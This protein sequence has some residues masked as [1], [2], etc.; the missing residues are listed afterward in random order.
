MRG[1]VLL[2]GTVACASTGGG[3]RAALAERAA[4]D[5]VEIVI[6]ATT[7]VHGRL[8][9]WD[10]YTGRPDSARGLARAATIIDSLRR[11]HAGR[12]VLLDAGDLL[13]GNPL[14]YHAARLDTLGL[15]PVIA[16]M[17]TM[18][19]AAAAVGN[20]E[21]NYGLHILGRATSSAT[22][23][24][25]AANVWRVN[26]ERAF[27][28][29]TV[30]E[31][32]GVRVAI[33]GAT[34]PGVM[35]WDRDKVSGRI[36]VR[37]I[38]PEVRRAVNEVRRAGADVVVVAIH[39]GFDEP[40]SYDTVSSGVPSENVSARV[41]REVPGIDVLVYGHSHR[42]QPGLTIESTLLIQPR[43]WATSVAIATLRVVRGA[44]VV[45][46]R[47]A[48]VQ[49][50]GHVE[51]SAV[52]AAVRQAHEGT[53][54]YVAT[55]VGETR[56]YWRGDSARVMDTPLIDF[57]NEVQ[58]RRTNSD[59]SAASAFSA[60]G[61]LDSGTITLA[62]IAQVYPY[63]N[64]LRAVRISGAQLRAY[65]EYSARYY[66]SLGS[67]P[68]I[69][70]TIPG[71]NFDIISGADYT[72]DLSKPLGA[73]VTSLSARGRPVADSD[74]FT[75]ALNDY[76]QSGGAG[77]AMLRGAPVVYDAKED[78]RELLI[79]EVRRRGTLR[80]EDFFVRNWRIEPPA[81]VAQ[82]AVELAAAPRPAVPA[83]VRRDSHLTNGRW[84]RVIATND[85]HGALEPR[86]DSAGGVVR[87]GAPYLAAEIAQARRACAA[88][89]C[90]SL[91]LDGGD[92]FQG[93][94]AS[95]LAYGRPVMTIFN[96][97]G[98]S[99][100]ALG[101]H[102][103]DWGID[104]LRALMRDA[105]YP[106]LGANVR[107][108]Q[109]GDIPWIPDDT[110]VTAGSLK[111]GVI[112]A[113]LVETPTV[114]KASVVKDLRFV[115][116][117]PLIDALSRALRARGADV[118]IVVAH[119]GAFCG[120]EVTTCRGAIVDLAARL[121]ERVD[122][123]VSGHTHSPV[124]GIVRGIPIVQARSRGTALGMIDIPLGDSAAAPVIELRDVRADWV[125]PDST[126]AAIVRAAAERVAERM[127]VPVAEIGENLSLGLRS[128]LGGLIADAQRH[129]GEGDVALM[130]N[131]GVRAPIR[132]GTATVGSL[133]EVHPF[134]NRLVR[135]Q[136]TGREL[137]RE[138]E[139]QVAQPTFNLHVSGA[140]I[141]FD[142][143]RPAGSRVMSL[144]LSD[145]T[146][147]RDRGRYRVVLSD[148]LAD[149]GD[150]VQLAQSA[151]RRED[152][153]ITDLDVL[154]A[155]FKTLP[156]PV[157]A[158]RDVRIRFANP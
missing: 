147:I 95:N 23:P 91:W 54:R 144:T 52:V 10:Y 107:D 45:A 66:R 5:T 116:P 77:F 21:F 68:L 137:R 129:V 25:L 60:T 85:F 84:L 123:I 62:Q 15:H 50:A 92:M 131:G 128:P 105:R 80:H 113:A 12:V 2:L 110:L 155:Y 141:V 35:I 20:H 122:A 106:I 48:V 112:G 130:N 120:R 140:R 103:F 57:I 8:R 7:D 139:R 18:R 99:A 111:V 78:I 150:G 61:G 153:G 109:G 87:G 65:L 146:P 38:V 81:A 118:V 125:N 151:L 56:V 37:D 134:G 121:T 101:N 4:N 51:D 145:S 26:G 63:E 94:P 100:A 143:T 59:L 148:F 53:I 88:P 104:T 138:L 93:T 33:V 149:G 58:R 28:A 136:V 6:A 114:T 40:S 135:L 157:R 17:N 102:E 1:A 44:G 70:S 9:G 142:T 83:P 108:A 31:R 90:A 156:R 67:T 43:H 19:Y 27:P 127:S 69:D 79:D 89:R 96:A 119:I 72:L 36:Q 42:E 47:G 22:F 152:L 32:A 98:L 126:V 117:A 46:R 13:Q 24:F 73:R 49:A 132:A 82:A 154:I 39:S 97:L 74:S 3:E 71:Y 34:N 64:T 11:A 16:A 55:P 158:Q 86:A 124:R 41:A 14:T 29:S 30:I 76:R 75:L 115:D 133:Y